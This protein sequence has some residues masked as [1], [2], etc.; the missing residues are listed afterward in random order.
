MDIANRAMRRAMVRKFGT[1]IFHGPLA[2][3]PAR[4]GMELVDLRSL[5]FIPP[6]I[7][8]AH[9]INADADVV[10][11][12][13][14]GVDLNTMWATL[15]QVLSVQNAE[16]DRLVQFLTFPVVNDVDTIPQGGEEEFE[17]ASEFGVPQ[18][19]R[20]A[21]TYFQMGYTFKWYDIGS[22]YTWQF[23]ADAD[24]RQVNQ[25]ANSVL[26]ADNRLIFKQVMKTIFNSTNLTA[27]IRGN[28]Y[29]VYKFYNADGT[30]PP[31]YKT[32]TFDGTHTHY[33]A[34]NGALAP[35]DVE[36]MQ[37]QLNHHGYTRSNGYRLVLMVNK[38]EMDQIRTWKAGSTY[39]GSVATYDFIPAV[40]QPGVLLPAP[41]VGVGV[42]QPANTLD[43]LDVM[44]AYGEWIIISDDYITPGYLFG[45]ATGG[46]ESLNNPVGFR[47]HKQTSMRGLKL[48]K[49]RNPD[50][51]IIDSYWTR[52]FGTGIRQRGGGVVMK[53]TAG[54]DTTYTPP[55]EYV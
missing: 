55:T 8:G 46:T 45:F 33:L 23:L 4:P 47:Q 20:T 54:G 10:T 35:A 15:Q 29:N 52:G 43:G 30:V 7:G 32:N 34:S 26:N 21:L 44:G 27:T 24:A 49:G 28:S 13:A 18:S 9:G 41:V 17:E 11:Q 51:P 50:Y 5:G 19:V 37:T 6:V 53:V 16:R 12:T 1:D 48:V 40:G 42:N 14:D 31:T 22:R 2:S 25:I 36:G 3:A 38:V 39:N